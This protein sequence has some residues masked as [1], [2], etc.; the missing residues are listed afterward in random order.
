MSLTFDSG[1]ASLTREPGLDIFHHTC[2]AD[3]ARDTPP[4]D[5][6]GSME[7]EPNQTRTWMDHFKCIQSGQVKVSLLLHQ[8]LMP[9]KLTFPVI[10]FATF[11]V[12]LTSNIP[13]LHCVTLY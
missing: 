9:A 1:S 12:L 13:K 10:R 7:P 3:S 11:F 4:T 2:I 8:I 6:F 5:E